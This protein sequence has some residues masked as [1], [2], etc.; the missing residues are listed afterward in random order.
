MPLIFCLS[1]LLLATPADQKEP[2]LVAPEGPRSPAE[3]QKMFHLPPGFK[4]ELIAAEPQ[5]RKPMNL[6]FD[7]RGRLV[8]TQ[9]IE[10]PFPAK[11][12]VTPR[13]TVQIFTDTNG[14]GVPDKP[15]TFADG[16][17]IPIGVCPLGE[18]ALV[19]S[20]PEIRMFSQLD[21]NGKATKRTPVYSGF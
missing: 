8:V 6:A 15:H 21:M 20:I 16:L 19:Y 9:S 4:I 12:G 14:D 13:D 17:N 1:S 5:I 3:Q 2:P 10:Y 7:H 18:D 11:E